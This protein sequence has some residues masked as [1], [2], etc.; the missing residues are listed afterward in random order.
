MTGY[1]QNLP[2][3]SITVS[4][5]LLRPAG[6]QEFLKNYLAGWLTRI[7][8]NHECNQAISAAIVLQEAAGI[9]VIWLANGDG[10][11]KPDDLT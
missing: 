3:F 8:W 7:A 6:L 2:L 1:L 5:S 4:G 11:A 10:R 9:D